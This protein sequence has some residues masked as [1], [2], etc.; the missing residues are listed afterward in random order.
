MG[1]DFEGCNDFTNKCSQPETTK[2]FYPF[3]L[4]CDVLYS[5]SPDRE[6]DPVVSVGPSACV[7]TTPL[8]FWIPFSR[9]HCHSNALVA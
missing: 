8:T 7:R 3:P 2:V 9:G 5:C 4:P 1:P 6:K